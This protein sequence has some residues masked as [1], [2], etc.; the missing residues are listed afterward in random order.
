MA[1]ATTS[2]HP[3]GLTFEKVREALLQKQLEELCS[4]D[5]FE[6]RLITPIIREEFKALHFD[7]P[8]QEDVDKHVERMEVLRLHAAP[9]Q[10]KF[11]FQGAIAGKVMTQDVRDYAYKTG[12]YV[13]EKTRDW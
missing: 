11:K 9:Y 7:E 6:T 10:A 1:K 4:Y 2:N 5:E 3:H 12:F 8:S 13:L